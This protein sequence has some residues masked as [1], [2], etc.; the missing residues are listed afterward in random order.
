MTVSG[1]STPT[2]KQEKECR[3]LHPPGSEDDAL[4]ALAKENSGPGKAKPPPCSRDYVD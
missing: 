2:I 4:Y 1:P 3:D